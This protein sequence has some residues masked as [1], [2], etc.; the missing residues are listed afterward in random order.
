MYIR[1][2]IIEGITPEVEDLGAFTLADGSEAVRAV[3]SHSGGETRTV[4]HTLQVSKRK[5]FTYVLSLTANA[6]DAQRFSK[7]F[8]AMLSGITTYEPAVYGVSRDRA[9]IMLLGEPQTMDP[10]LA[11]ETTSHMFVSSV[12]SGLVRFDRFQRAVPDLA[13]SWVVDETGTVY[14][15]TLRDWITFQD[16]RPITAHDFKY[17]IERASD[18]ELHSDTAPLYL[19]DI[20]GMNEKLAGEAG[21]VTGVEVIDNR[22]LRI[23]IDAPKEYFLAKLSYPSS[24]VV[25]RVAVEALGPDW[26]R[27]ERINGSGRY[28][29]WEWEPGYVVL[30]RYEGYHT[31]PDLEYI[32][33]PLST[34]P[35]ASGLDMYLGD[36][37][38]A[39]FVGPT[40]LDWIREDPE[41]SEQLHVFDQFTSYFVVMDSTQPPFDD[42][43]VRRA[44]AMAVDRERLVEEVL[45]GGVKVANGLLPPGI[46]GYHTSL[47]GIPYDPDMARQLLAE[48]KYGN[49]LPDIIYTVPSRGA[50]ATVTFMINAWRE[51]L[52]VQVRVERAPDDYFYELEG[53]A[54]NMYSYGWVADYPDPENFLDVLLHSSRHDSRYV[55][56]EFDSLVER[57][58]TEMDWDVRLSLYQQAEQL[59]MDD[60]G[61]IPLFHSQDFVLVRPHVEGFRMLP[62][63]QPDLT[64]LKL[65]PFNP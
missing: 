36:A 9:F 11:R 51:E 27:A 45:E 52:G 59:L 39:A 30:S 14:T 29:L 46:P 65:N 3:L 15:F 28:R 32:V 6:D 2:E 16:N 47:R 25:D 53:S 50:S 64:G 17:S 24:Y 42:P 31:P 26:W 21:E 41:L 34:L 10:A 23:T 44:F 60:A 38:D 56:E 43:N 20:V 62:V 49:N 40:S 1:Q 33:S 19:G 4:L 54:K 63:G 5:T 35:G 8:D 13:E 18:P 48:S 37:W 61:I 57:A 22:T 12:F 55:S 58:R 7:T